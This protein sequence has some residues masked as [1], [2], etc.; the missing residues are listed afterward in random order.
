MLFVSVKRSAAILF[1]EQFL[2]PALHTFWQS[3]ARQIVWHLYFYMYGLRHKQNCQSRV[4][5]L[6]KALFKDSLA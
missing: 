6:G 2:E 4:Y 5:N 3:K 1:I